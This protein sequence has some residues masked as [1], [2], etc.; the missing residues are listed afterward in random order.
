[1]SQLDDWVLCR[2]YKKRRIGR[3]LEEKI[4]NPQT[5]L[6][7]TV[8]RNDA[9]EQQMLKFPRTCSLSH[10]WEFD[11]MGPISQLLNPETCNPN[12]DFQNIVGNDGTD[13]VEKF[14][15]GEMP[16]QYTESGKFYVNQGGI[17]NKPLFLNP[18]VSEFQ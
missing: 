13:P 5:Q 3:H 15:I 8:A 2:I 14:Q 17:L 11:Y 12:F 7:F 4:E 18:M 10:L 6:G 1:M 9:S 16:L